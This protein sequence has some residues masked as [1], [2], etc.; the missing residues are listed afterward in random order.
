MV[1][2][3]DEVA[4]PLVTK[5]RLTKG[6]KEVLVTRT[7]G[8]AGTSRV[9]GTDAFAIMQRKAME[10]SLGSDDPGAEWGLGQGL[11]WGE[12][13]QTKWHGWPGVPRT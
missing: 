12:A 7:Y 10:R 8:T 3:A 9:E 5:R 1:T 2:S 4:G 13:C 6:T 11:S